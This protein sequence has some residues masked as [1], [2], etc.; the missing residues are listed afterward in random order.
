MTKDVGYVGRLYIRFQLCVHRPVTLRGAAGFKLSAEPRPPLHLRTN[1]R[2]NTPRAHT[3]PAPRAFA[4]RHAPQRVHHELRRCTGS[5]P[6]ALHLPHIIDVEQPP[7]QPHHHRHPHHIHL[8]H[9]LRQRMRQA[10]WTGKPRRKKGTEGRGGAQRGRAGAHGREEDGGDEGGASIF[11]NWGTHMKIDGLKACAFG[12]CFFRG[13]ALTSSSGTSPPRPSPTRS[14]APCP[15]LTL[16]LTSGP[17]QAS[18]VARRSAQTCA[19]RRP[20]S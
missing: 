10:L 19:P 16:T 2:I 18:M 3:Q 7:R 9:P 14:G 13:C 11:S 20:A 6:P 4:I 17:V 1:T 15:T 8:V 5:A 12:G